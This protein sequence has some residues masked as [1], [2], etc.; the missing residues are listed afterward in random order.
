[1]LTDCSPDYA[2][3]WQ[4]LDRWLDGMSQL[5]AAAEGAGSLGDAVGGAASSILAQL[6]GL[7]GRRPRSPL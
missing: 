7:V 2:D 3:T 1:M 4:A 6:G 5:G